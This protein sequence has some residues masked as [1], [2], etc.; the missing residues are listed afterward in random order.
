M[1]RTAGTQLSEAR[2]VP[3]GTETATTALG[4][5]RDDLAAALGLDGMCQSGAAFSDSEVHS[6]PDKAIVCLN[7][8]PVPRL[9]L[10]VLN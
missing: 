7:C 8:E 3:P 1:N 9:D 10:S 2:D 6:E 4:A 5:R